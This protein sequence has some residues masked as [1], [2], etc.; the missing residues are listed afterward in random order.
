[1]NQIINYKISHYLRHETNDILWTGSAHNQN[2][3]KMAFWN[4][5]LYPPSSKARAKNISEEKLLH[6]WLIIEHFLITLKMDFFALCEISEP[7]IENLENVLSPK[8]YKISRSTASDKNLIQDNALIYNSKIF[9]LIDKK[10]IINPHYSGRLKVATLYQIQLTDGD[11]F[12]IYVCHWPSRLSREENWLGRD[13]LGVTMRAE[14]D[15][16]MQKEGPCTKIIVMGDFNDEPF[17]EPIADK[18]MA[19]RDMGLVIANRRFLYNPFW[20]KL[21]GIKSY[22]K[23]C[24]TGIPYGTYFY[25]NAKGNTKWHT[26][27]QIIFSS[28]FVAKSKWHLREED[29]VIHDEILNHVIVGKG[30]FDHLPISAIIEKE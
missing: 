16:L 2:T 17:N 7:Y 21:G 13:D 22:N 4:T 8:G 5:G 9:Q 30:I 24:L 20:R 18:L 25:K 14:I 10:D 1:M 6:A 29:T 11:L 3:I 19:S 23:D 15:L 28:S 12:N 27:D 26:F